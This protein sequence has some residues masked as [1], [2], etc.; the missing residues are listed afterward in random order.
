LL[1]FLPEAEA[2]ARIEKLE[3]ELRKA[4][5]VSDNVDGSGVKRKMDNQQRERAE[6]QDSRHESTATSAFVANLLNLPAG[7]RAFRSAKISSL[8]V[9]LLS[10]AQFRTSQ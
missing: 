10:G 1:E 9:H 7:Y 2:Q 6:S 3:N 5:E 8:A 4:R